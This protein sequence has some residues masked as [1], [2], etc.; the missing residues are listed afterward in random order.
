[1]IPVLT[2]CT[3][4]NDVILGQLQN[5]KITCPHGPTWAK[6]LLVKWNLDNVMVSYIL[7]IMILICDKIWTETFFLSPRQYLT[8]FIAQGYI[9]GMLLIHN[10]LVLDLFNCPK[11]PNMKQTIRDHHKTHPI[12]NIMQNLVDLILIWVHNMFLKI[13]NQ[14]WFKSPYMSVIICCQPR[15]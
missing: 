8:N 14:I 10:N 4:L 13:K 2:E 9:L 11:S 3:F 1:M 12:L 15:Q 5:G 7:I 6:F